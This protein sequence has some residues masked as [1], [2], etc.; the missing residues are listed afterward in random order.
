M[1]NGMAEF[2]LRQLMWRPWPKLIQLK[3]T[4]TT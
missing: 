3:Y 1:D 4:K 2:F